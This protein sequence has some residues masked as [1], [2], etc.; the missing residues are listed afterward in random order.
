MIV[1][2]WPSR[3]RIP[4]DRETGMLAVGAGAVWLTGAQ[5]RFVWQLD[6][7]TGRVLRAIRLRKK[8]AHTCGMKATS[9]AVC[10]TIATPTRSRC[11]TGSRSI[12]RRG[13]IAFG[14]RVVP[15][16]ARDPDGG[17]RAF[18]NSCA[19]RRPLTRRPGRPRK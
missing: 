16:S 13:Q 9:N 11:S 12:G 1:S 19:V 14:V 10:V 4:L 17:T 6:P 3:N 7:K 15:G 8:G 2:G 5:D 18:R